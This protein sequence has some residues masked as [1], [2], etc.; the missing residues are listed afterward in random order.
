MTVVGDTL[1][2]AAWYSQ[3]DGYELWKSDGTASGTVMV[4]NINTYG[5]KGSEPRYLR[6]ADDVLY[7]FADN[8]TSFRYE[9]LFEFMEE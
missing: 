9:Q 3:A 4:K 5:Q 8:T 2:F 6:A 7:F 1:F